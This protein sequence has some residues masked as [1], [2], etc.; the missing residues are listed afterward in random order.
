MVKAVI[1][2]NVPLTMNYKNHDGA[3]S[4][5]RLSIVH[6]GALGQDSSSSSSDDDNDD[7]DGPPSSLVQASPGTQE[8]PPKSDIT[9]TDAGCSG[10]GAGSSSV[11]HKLDAG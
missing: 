11:H 8:Q 1:T 2:V 7:V 10:A 3:G 6:I 4:M 5:G 9:M